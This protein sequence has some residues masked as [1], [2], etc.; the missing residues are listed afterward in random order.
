YNTGR[1][2]AHWR[3]FS[4]DSFT[5]C[6]I[7]RPAASLSDAADQVAVKPPELLT[8]KLTADEIAVISSGLRMMKK[9]T[10]DS[11]ILAAFDTLAAA[12]ERASK[13]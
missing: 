4:C 12:L 11:T 10:L 1:L 9:V 13:G 6:V 3:C 5:R 2:R 8:I 7:I